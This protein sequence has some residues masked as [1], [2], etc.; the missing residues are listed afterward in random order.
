MWV[1]AAPAEPLSQVLDAAEDASP[2]QAVEAVTGALAAALNAEAAFFLIADVSGRGFVRLSHV[3]PGRAADGAGRVGDA[4]GVRFDDQERAESLPFDGGPAEEALRTQMVQV[5]APSPRTAAGNGSDQWVVLAPVTERGEALGLLRLTLPDEPPAAV[6][7]QIA[8]IGHVLAFVVIANRRHTDLFEWAQRSASFSLPA[9]IQRRLLPAAF[10]C[11]AG[12]FVLSAWLEPAATIGG[13]TFDY[14]LARDALHLSMTDA[15]GHGVASA[16]TATLCVG[17]LRNTRRAGGSL[18]EQ[19]AVANRALLE[20]A[21]LTSTEGFATGLLGRIDLRTGRLSLVNAGHVSPYLCRAG[22][23]TKVQLPVNL[24]MGLFADTKYHSTDLD[25]ETGDRLVLV[26][27]GMLERNAATLDLIAEISLSRALHPREA[28]R[29]LTDKVLETCQP[30]LADDATMLV[31]DWHGE[32]GG[33][34]TTRSGAEQSLASAATP[35]P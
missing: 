21:S 27:D 33:D 3:T 4:G 8:R 32:H 35:Q 6:L 15:M 10:T 19:A 30:A 7:A 26:T 34:R 1:E 18:L 16:L 24:P 14:S 25:L 17:S 11:E 28:T 23:V 29:R 2:L 12:A 31:L 22:A 13:D 5:V 20:H 9:E